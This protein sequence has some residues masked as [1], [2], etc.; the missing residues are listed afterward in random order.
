LGGDPG[1][2]D[3]PVDVADLESSQQPVPGDVAEA[4]VAAAESN[5]AA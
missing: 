4:F 2:G 5:S 1:G 3:S